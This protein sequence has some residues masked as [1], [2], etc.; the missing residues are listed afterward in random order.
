MWEQHY[1]REICRFT[2][3]TSKITSLILDPVKQSFLSVSDDGTVR[4]WNLRG[5][6]PR[7][8]LDAS[9]CSSDNIPSPFLRQN[10]YYPFTQCDQLIETSKVLKTKNRDDVLV[11]AVFSHQDS[12]K[13]ATGSKRGKVIV[14]KIKLYSHIY[15]EFLWFWFTFKNMDF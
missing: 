3:H 7:N 10:R 5:L 14:K 12:F 4:L 13:V 6:T 15:Y 9:D 1:K 2:G 8:S 11:S